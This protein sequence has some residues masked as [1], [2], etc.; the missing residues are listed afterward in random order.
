MLPPKTAGSRKACASQPHQAFC[1]CRPPEART[2]DLGKRVRPW[3]I[4]H[5]LASSPFKTPRRRGD[6]YV[7]VTSDGSSAGI[8]ERNCGNKGENRWPRACTSIK[9]RSPKW[10]GART[11]ARGDPELRR[12]YQRLKFRRSSGVAKVA[13][14]R[15]LAVRLYW[16]LRARVDYAQRVRMSGSPGSAVV[17]PTAGS[18]L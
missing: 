5:T 12:A 14:A 4:R 15:R 6:F 2:A 17:P 10:S 11:A 7:A 3:L 16:M 9:R 13:M 8:S 1:R 18:K